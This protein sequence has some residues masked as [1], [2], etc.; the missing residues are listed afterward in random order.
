[1]YLVMSLMTEIEI[2][3]GP[4]EITEELCWADGMIG[5]VPVFSTREEAEAFSINNERILEVQYKGD[6][7]SET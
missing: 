2:E 3:V 6:N 4:T 7:T 5:A 1:M